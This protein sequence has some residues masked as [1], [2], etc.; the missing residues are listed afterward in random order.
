MINDMQKCYLS[1]Y[2]KM[3]LEQNEHLQIAKQSILVA[4][5]IF[6]GMTVVFA[7]YGNILPM[8][9]CGILMIAFAVLK[10]VVGHKTK[11]DVNDCVK[12]FTEKLEKLA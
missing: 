1:E 3:Y 11:D 4:F 2:V 10:F 7:L 6:G 8:I 12:E 5:G 9:T